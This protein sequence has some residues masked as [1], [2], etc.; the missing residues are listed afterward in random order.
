MLFELHTIEGPHSVITITTTAI[1]IS[2]AYSPAN[3]KGLRRSQ[4]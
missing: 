4:G 2:E 3:W 1:I